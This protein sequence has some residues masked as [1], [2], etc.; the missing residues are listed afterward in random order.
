MTELT[1]RRQGDL[2]QDVIL[3]HLTYGVYYVAQ[4]KRPESQV[5]PVTDGLAGLEL[6]GDLF[7]GRVTGEGD[8]VVGE[9]ER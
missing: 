4:G 7:P 8:E 2:F 1:S 9:A 3:D 5:R 6:P